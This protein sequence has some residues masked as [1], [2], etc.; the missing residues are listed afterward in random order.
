MLRRRK[1]IFGGF[2][3]GKVGVRHGIVAQTRVVIGGFSGQWTR[4]PPRGIVG[5]SSRLV[6][7]AK[8][9]LTIPERWSRRRTKGTGAE[10]PGADSLKKRQIQDIELNESP[11][12]AAPEHCLP[13]GRT[14][15]QS[16][17]HPLAVSSK[18]RPPNHS[19]QVPPSRISR[20][21]IRP[22]TAAG[23]N[24]H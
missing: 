12:L 2:V 6:M 14:S 18:P 15:R 1:L 24:Q 3:A 8:A 20:H 16:R 19:H 4:S 10:N 11:M 5:R 17:H 7:R 13:A 21:P 22:H 9:R 23:A